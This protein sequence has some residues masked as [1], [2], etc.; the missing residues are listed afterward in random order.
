MIEGVI[1]KQL[2]KHSDQRGFLIEIF[3]EDD[4]DHKVAM[5]YLS[6]THPNIVRGPHE[7]NY[8]SD[9][10]VFPGPGD[11]RLYLW[12]NRPQSATFS[13][14]MTLDLGESNP[15]IVIIPPK[16]VHAYK[17]I[18]KG[19]ALSINLPDKL[20]KGTNKQ[21]EVDEIRWEDDPNSPFKVI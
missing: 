12:D 18:S 13:K 20:Y 11:F 19:S 14:K 21:E 10:F 6:L 1:I 8:Q 7:H 4:I 2:T 17:C 3:R 9:Y 5:S 16:V 15:C